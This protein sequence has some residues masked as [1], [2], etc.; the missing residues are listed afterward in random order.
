MSGISL[1]TDGQ[2]DVYVRAAYR[3]AHVADYKKWE[4]EEWEKAE[5]RMRCLIMDIAYTV[6]ERLRENKK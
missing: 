4:G 3:N 1:L 6:A 2:V 5:R